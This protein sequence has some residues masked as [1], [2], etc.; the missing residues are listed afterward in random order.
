MKEGK[1]YCD[2]DGVMWLCC[3]RKRP[4]MPL[5]VASLD[6]GEL[7]LFEMAHVEQWVDVKLSAVLRWLGDTG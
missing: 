4:E 6:T 3:R 1:V 7:R 2:V 5:M